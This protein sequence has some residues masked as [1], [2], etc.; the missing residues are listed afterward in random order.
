MKRKNML[1]DPNPLKTGP[2]KGSS[3]RNI[4]KKFRKNYDQINWGKKKNETT[5]R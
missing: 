5:K 1:N 3:P 2:G 4:S